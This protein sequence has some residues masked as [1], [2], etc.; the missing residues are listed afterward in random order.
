MGSKPFPVSGANID[1]ML[2]IRSVQPASFPPS[3]I[4]RIVVTRPGRGWNSCSV[5]GVLADPPY[6]NMLQ[7]QMSEKFTA[8]AELLGKPITELRYFRESFADQDV[9]E[10]AKK[11]SVFVDQTAADAITV[12]VLLKS[13]AKVTMRSADVADMS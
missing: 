5:P 4:E 10:V 13:G 2:I 11:T 12:E 8:T 3:E 6:K 7:A 1:A 9:A